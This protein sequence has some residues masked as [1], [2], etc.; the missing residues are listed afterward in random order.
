MRLDFS[1][2]SKIRLYDIAREGKYS[3]EML[4]GW[5]GCKTRGRIEGVISK[6]EA[7]GWNRM[8]SRIRFRH[9]SQ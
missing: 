2:P 1:R 3:M 8:G 7:R 5:S 4:K 9:A 6:D